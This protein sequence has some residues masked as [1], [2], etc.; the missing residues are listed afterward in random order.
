[1]PIINQPSP[2]PGIPSAVGLGDINPTL[3]LSPA[4]SG[5]LIWASNRAQGRPLWWCSPCRG[6]GAWGAGEQPV[7]VWGMGQKERELV[8]GPAIR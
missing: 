3:F 5:K 1:M 7:V 8:P 6:I 2:A 4:N